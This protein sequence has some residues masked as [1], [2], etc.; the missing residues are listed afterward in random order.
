[1]AS[2]VPRTRSHAIAFAIALTLAFP[3]PSPHAARPPAAKDGIPVRAA[4]IIDN[5]NRMDVNSL[6]MVVTNH[7]SFAY[8]LVTGNA[9]LVYPKGSGRTVLFAGGLWLGARVQ[10]ETR[11]AVA[12]YAQEYVPGPMMNGTFMPDEARFRNYQ[13]YR[14]NTTS[15][16]Y[17]EWPSGDGAPVDAT[18]HPLLSGDATVWSVYN[19][20]DPSAHFTGTAP[21]GIEIQQSTF[22]FNRTGPL[23]RTIFLKFKLTNEGGNTLDDTYVGLWLDPDLGFYADDLSGCDVGRGMG[24]TYNATNADAQYGSSPPAVGLDLL[25]GPIGAADTLGMTSFIRY[26]NGQDP[27]NAEEIYNNLRGLHTDGTPIHEFDDPS[28][29]TTTFMV[30]GDPVA[31][32]GWLD[33]LPADKRTLVASGPFRM[34]PGES[35]EII[36]AI[37]V[38]Q[39]ADRLASVADLRTTDDEVQRL[40][41]SGFGLPPE[42]EALPARVFANRGNQT[43]LLRSGRPSWCVRVESANGAFQATDVDPASFVLRSEG[44]GV[45]SE[46]SAIAG[47]PAIAS[48]TDGNGITESSPCF[49]SSDVARL[50][51]LIRGRTVVPVHVWASLFNGSRVHGSMDVTVIG[52]SGPVSAAVVPDEAGKGFRLEVYTREPGPLSVRI[53]DVQGRLRLTLAGDEWVPAGVHGYSLG[54]VRGA[55]GIGFYQVKTPAG[56][57]TGRIPI[58]R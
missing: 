22:A 27:V 6:D 20:A 44:T 38:G 4:A 7:G 11:V 32:T 17:R 8:D 13:I 12:D 28:R 37:I 41:E 52:S 16:D 57:A 50:F 2:R 34:L 15:A 29:P 42:P 51:S 48:D 25:R 33:T 3:I 35:Q 23:S 47:K 56:I 9:G 49:A 45:V 54:P 21:L 53:F 14:G 31:G 10:G 5:D 58:A 30:S 39:G 1:M 36:A 55:R 19:D 26:I 43:I 24:Y 40:F 18:G 46:I